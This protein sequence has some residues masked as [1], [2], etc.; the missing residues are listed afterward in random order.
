MLYK[1]PSSQ[2]TCSIPGVLPKAVEKIKHVSTFLFVQNVF[3]LDK[4]MK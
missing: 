3:G 1:A 2:N 4:E